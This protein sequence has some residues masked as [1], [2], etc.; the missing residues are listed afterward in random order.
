M[1]QKETGRELRIKNEVNSFRTA[2]S[3]T[4]Y[5]KLK[6][7]KNPVFYFWYFPLKIIFTYKEDSIPFS[8][9]SPVLTG[10]NKYILVGVTTQ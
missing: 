1:I 2:L 7:F 10:K 3:D 4:C 8:M 5:V 6:Y 9:F